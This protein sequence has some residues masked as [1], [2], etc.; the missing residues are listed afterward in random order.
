[1]SP[2]LRG[3]LL[4]AGAA[5]MAAIL[6]AVASNG[7]DAFAPVPFMSVLAFLAGR[8]PGRPV[9]IAVFALLMATVVA[10]QIAWPNGDT[11]VPELMLPITLFVAGVALRARDTIALKLADQAADIEAERE[12]YTRLSVRYERA[13]IAAELHDVVAHA[14]SV[15]V[16]QASAGQRLVDVEPELAT[17]TFGVIAIAARQAEADLD[18]LAGLLAQDAVGPG[19]D[20][21][22]VREIVDRAC[23]AGLPVTLRLAG[24]SEGI[25]GAVA[26]AGFRV[27]QEGLTNALRYAPGAPVTV[28]VRAGPAALDVRVEN[29][30]PTEHA[31][32]N[33]GS[34]HGLN[35]L[36]ER[37]AAC[38]G[39]LDAG[40]DA[41]GGWTVHASMPR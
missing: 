20:L 17:E 18:R 2:R 40:P 19:E 11:V 41:R 1:M 16:V 7:G 36:R 24:S 13:R 23:A 31:E 3:R 30:A 38:G 5:V 10:T 4:L 32:L 27:V 21:L 8:H 6:V 35:G 25:R 37:V 22:L 26:H 28:T 9:G 14:I 34:S 12:A 15:M 29:E 33:L 39:T